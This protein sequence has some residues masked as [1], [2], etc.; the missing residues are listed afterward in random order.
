M[1]SPSLIHAVFFAE[2]ASSI[3]IVLLLVLE[4]I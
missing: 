2:M 1:A 3:S 4:P